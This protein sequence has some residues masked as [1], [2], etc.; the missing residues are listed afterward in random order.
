MLSAWFLAVGAH[1]R[2]RMAKI[3]A[4]ERRIEKD[5]RYDEFLSKMESALPGVTWKDLQNDPLVVDEL[6][7]K[8]AHEMYPALFSTPNSFSSSIEGFFQFE[9]QRALS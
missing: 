6:I 7:P 4:L 5:G 2:P 3:A 9:D 1:G 8:I